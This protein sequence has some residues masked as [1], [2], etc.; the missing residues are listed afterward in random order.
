MV[1]SIL[2]DEEY[3]MSSVARVA[4]DMLYSFR[5]IRFELIVGIGGGVPFK[6]DI[7]LGDIL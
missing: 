4:R 2:Q 6:H 7:R 1:I 3:G 5:N